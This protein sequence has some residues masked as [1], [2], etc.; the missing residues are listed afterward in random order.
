MSE[1]RV[2]EEGST[3]E[4]FM[5]V[6]QKGAEGFVNG[7][8]EPL[9]SIVTKTSPAT[10]FGPAGGIDQGAEKVAAIYRRDTALFESGE[11]QLEVLHMGASGDIGYWVGVQRA[12]VRMKGKPET[13]SMNLR[14]SEIFRREG[15]DWK[16]IHRHADPLKD[17]AK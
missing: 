17:D 9:G 7:K 3:F 13:I 11:T 6:R 15:E 5:K 16:L 4:E 12:K 10:F 8:E 14:I 1:K 2:S